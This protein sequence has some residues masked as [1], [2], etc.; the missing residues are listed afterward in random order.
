MKIKTMRYYS[1]SL[2]WLKLKTNH[3][4]VG[5]SVEQLEHLYTTSGNVKWYNH[6]GKKLIYQFFL[7]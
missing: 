2:E 4:S 7:L 3:V 5:E 1:Y 6:F